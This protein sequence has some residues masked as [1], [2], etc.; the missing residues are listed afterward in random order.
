MPP[1]YITVESVESDESTAVESD[2]DDTNM[3]APIPVRTHVEYPWK[4]IVWILLM[5][6]LFIF[7]I[8]YTISEFHVLASM[9]MALFVTLLTY[10]FLRFGA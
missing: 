1:R 3:S 5:V 10:L 9:A 6:F 2:L 8:L 7:R 4:A